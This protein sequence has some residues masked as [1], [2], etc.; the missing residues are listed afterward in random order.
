MPGC[1]TALTRSR[2]LPLYTVSVKLEPGCL[3]DVSQHVQFSG[4]NF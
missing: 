3:Y 1:S 4:S 2:L